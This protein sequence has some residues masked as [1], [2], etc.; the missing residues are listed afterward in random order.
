M[1]N[2]TVNLWMNVLLFA[3]FFGE[4]GL[5]PI[6]WW[7]PVQLGDEFFRSKMRIGVAVTGDA[8]CHRELFVLIDHVH[9]V[10]PTMTALAA[11]TCVHVG[12]V[13]EVHELGQV[14]HSR[15]TNALARFP[16]L[17]DRRQFGTFRVNGCQRRDALI[18]RRAMTIDAR[19]CGRN[20]RVGR[21]EDGVVAI[22]A[23]QFQLAGMDGVTKWNGLLRLVAHVQCVGVSDQPSHRGSKNAAANDSNAEDSQKRVDPSWE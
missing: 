17:V 3:N 14:M 20:R 18:I 8:P 19:G 6:G 23:I 22:P 11:D 12:C 9:L 15:P 21:L 1:T 4:S 5:V 16:T 10:D 7:F 2:G 13:I